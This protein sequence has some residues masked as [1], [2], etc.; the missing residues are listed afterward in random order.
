LIFP[1]ADFLAPRSAP[2][3]PEILRVGDCTPAINDD[4]VF[5]T[6]DDDSDRTQ[7]YRVYDEYRR[8]RNWTHFVCFPL[9]PVFPALVES[10]S[11]LLQSWGL[12]PRRSG[13]STFHLTLALFVLN[14]DDDVQQMEQIV[15]A[16]ISRMTWPEDRT[17]TFPTLN[18]FGN[19][20]KASILFVEASGR[21]KD[22]P[23]QFIELLAANARSAGFARM[24]LGLPLHA[25]LLRPNHVA[26]RARVFDA[27]TMLAEF[28][29]DT[30]EPIECGELRLVKR[31]QYDDDG[32]YH[33]EATFDVYDPAFLEDIAEM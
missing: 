15:R 1:L 30:L 31:G 24:Q 23:E 16:T 2:P 28:R 12:S 26:P 27:R 17:M 4:S 18:V 5:Y 29:P 11:T 6:F 22:A 25:T 13:L 32:F 10:L 33:T 19:P 8:R 3:T 9:A 7:I 14:D 21:F 20:G